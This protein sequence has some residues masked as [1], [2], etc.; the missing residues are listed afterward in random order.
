VTAKVKDSGTRQEY[1]T[2]ARRDNPENKGRMD[3]VPAHAILRLSR[4]YEWGAMKYG[5]NNWQKGMPISRYLDAALRHTFKYLAGCNDEDHLAA[6]A[7][8]ILA[9]MDHEARIPEFQDLRSWDGK[10]SKWIYELDFGED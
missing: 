3:L 7:W 9:V 1:E 5:D 6:A 10:K 2:G 8:N 4:W